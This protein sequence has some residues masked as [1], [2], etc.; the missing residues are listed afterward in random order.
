[1]EW[2]EGGPFLEI[3]FLLELRKKKKEAIQDIINKLSKVTYKI[4]IVD[5][6]IDEMLNAFEKGHPFDSED[7]Q[8][9]YLH[10]L[11]LRLYVYLSR[12]RKETLQIEKVSSNAIMVNFWFYGSKLD[13]LEW[14][15]V[16][17][18]ED[19]IA[20]FPNFFTELFSVYEYKV[21]GMALEEDVLG[22]FDCNEEYPSEC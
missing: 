15:Q 1:M 21:G 3:S 5:H 19:E 10:S 13:A 22:L 6:N 17:I 12:K 9:I 20:D 18:L 8:S 11:R 16:G 2:L 7:S 14:E 4:E